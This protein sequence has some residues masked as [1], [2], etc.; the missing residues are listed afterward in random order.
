MI[1]IKKYDYSGCTHGERKKA[2]TS[3]GRQ[4]LK[5]AVQNVSGLDTE[6]MSITKNEHGKPY[7]QDVKG[8]EF[9]ISHSGDYV[10]VMIG[11]T[12]LGVDIQIIRPVRERVVHK[13]CNEAERSFVFGSD[14]AD[15]AFIRLWTLKE[16]YVKAIGT[17][18]SFPMSTVNFDMQNANSEIVGKI[19]NCQGIFLNRD[20]GDYI[21][22]ACVI[23]EDMSEGR[24]KKFFEIKVVSSA[25]LEKG[26]LNELC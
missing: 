18:M 9:N 17:G 13:M 3:N 25:D 8:I 20:F 4:L 23:D 21:L 12:K 22:S 10:A 2:E 5:Y 15:R 14:D 19:S 7:F 6:D 24:L 26:V 1:F 16:S 11:D